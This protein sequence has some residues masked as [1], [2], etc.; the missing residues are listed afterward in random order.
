[1]TARV[2]KAFFFVLLTFFA[3][4]SLLGILDF[5]SIAAA[6]EAEPMH[7]TF[8]PFVGTSL[9][10]GG[11][12]QVIVGEDILLEDLI[13]QGVLLALPNDE[14]NDAVEIAANAAV[15]FVDCEEGNDANDGRSRSRAWR[16]LEKVNSATLMPGDRLRFKRGCAWDGPLNASWHGTASRPIIITSYGAGELPKIQNGY[17]SNVRISGSYQI[18]ENLH[19][20]LSTPPNPDPNCNNQPVGWKAGFSFQDGASYNVV[21]N[22]QATRLAIGI[23]FSGNTHHNKALNNSLT[24]NNVVWELTPDRTLGA[25]GVLLQGDHQEV[26]Y[27]YFAD[28][29]TRCTYTGVIESN[30]IELYAATNSTIH[31]NTSFRDRVFSEL[32]SS[33][34]VRSENNTYAYNLHV[35]ALSD[36]NYGARFVVTRGWDHTHGPVLSTKVYNNTLYLTGSGSKGVVCEKCGPNILNLEN[37]ILWVN[38]EPFSSDGPF[39]EKNNIFWGGGGSTLLNYY[40]FAMSESSRTSNPN[41]VDAANNNFHLKPD[42]PAVNGG[43]RAA[44][45]VG[46]DF[47]LW[48]TLTAVGGTPDIGAYEYRTAAWE[49]VFEL[50]SRIEAEDYRVGGPGVGYFDTTDG[51]SGR[52]YRSDGV[53]IE[54]T[55]DNGGGYD[56]GWMAPEEWL[57]YDINASAT[58]TYQVLVRAATP[59]GGRRFHIEIDGRDVTGS[60]VIPWTSSWQSWIYVP[61]LIPLKSGRHTLRLVAESDRFNINYL[62]ISKVQ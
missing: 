43:T 24:N 21:Q 33:P 26:G 6:E 20:T 61:V 62:I 30:S 17:S 38:R 2:S 11:G 16:T 60:I 35:S 51:N 1:M 28:N 13:G 45:D 14:P 44:V 19:A 7:G 41:F 59:S 4:T 49:R 46:F 58:G 32:G 54:A 25:M 3:A 22:S 9:E 37:N 57:A 10:Q 31:H 52:A 36:P 23:F 39:V 47:D 29:K 34:S 42:S 15:Y 40:G 5:G 48:Q 18:F 8:L 53:D 50:P 56:V 12:E 55:D 27:N